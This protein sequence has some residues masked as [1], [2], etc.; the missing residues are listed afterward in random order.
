MD[1]YHTRTTLTDKKISITIPAFNEEETIEQV[2]KNVL[3]SVK[4]IS[5]HFEIL[6]VDDGSTDRTA[7]IA[8]NLRSRNPERIR[9]IHHKTNKGFSAAMNTCYKN[10]DGDYI[11]L[12]P[13]DGQFDYREVVLFVRSIKN[14]DVVAGYRVFNEEHLYRKFNSLFF[15]LLAKTLFG[16]KLK[17]FSSCILYTKKVR[18]SITVDADSYACLFL[19]EFIYKSLHRGYKIGEVPIHFYA[20]KGGKQK[21]TNIRMIVRTIGEML[22]FKYSL[23]KNQSRA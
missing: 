12:G 18:D 7:E 11:F 9:V 1:K 4:H 8:E 2:V 23:M 14:H 10:A 21:G 16:I 19:P 22:L 3:I 15:H 5:T 20:R 13:A 6:L 17:E